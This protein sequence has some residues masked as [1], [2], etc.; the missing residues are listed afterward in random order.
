MNYSSLVIAGVSFAA[1]SG[2]CHA[3]VNQVGSIHS[4]TEC[5]ANTRD[6]AQH[7]VFQTRDGKMLNGINDRIT[8][9]HRNFKSDGKLY[10]LGPRYVWVSEMDLVNMSEGCKLLTEFNPGS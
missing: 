7:T 8:F 10:Y 1:I 2:G 5:T 4:K 9:M 6:G 3:Q